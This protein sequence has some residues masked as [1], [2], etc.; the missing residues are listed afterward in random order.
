MS[1]GLELRTDPSSRLEEATSVEGADL[2]VSLSVWI[3][4]LSPAHSPQE[5]C[6]ESVHD[7]FA[8]LCT[9]LV[10]VVGFACPDTFTSESRSDGTARP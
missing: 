8:R 10:L 2:L 9:S 6:G 3:V 4:K 7:A 1:R 5:R